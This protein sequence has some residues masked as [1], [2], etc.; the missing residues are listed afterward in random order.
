MKRVF[1]AAV[2]A[3]V[4]VGAQA[5]MTFPRSHAEDT[6]GYMSEAY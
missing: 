4:A 1:L 5:Q 6:K 2:L 3:V